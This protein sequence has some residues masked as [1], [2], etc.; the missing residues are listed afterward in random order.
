MRYGQHETF[1]CVKCVHTK[2]E[3]VFLIMISNRGGGRLNA[4]P[5]ELIIPLYVILN[6]KFPCT[7]ATRSSIEITFGFSRTY[8]WVNSLCSHH[9]TLVIWQVW[10]TNESWS[11]PFFRGFRVSVQ[12]SVRIDS[13]NIHLQR[14]LGVRRLPIGFPVSRELSTGL[15][16]SATSIIL[17][18][19]SISL[20]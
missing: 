17:W 9:A 1:R 16:M 12:A 2:A 13:A 11:S 5:S 20:R 10:A 14:L 6:L 7:F 15:L 19:H 18:S 3:N 4:E 8:G